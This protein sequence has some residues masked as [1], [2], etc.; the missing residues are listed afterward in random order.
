MAASAKRK[1][2]SEA[3]FA[4][5]IGMSRTG[6]Q[7]AK[8]SGRLVLFPDGSIDMAASAQRMGRGTDPSKQRGTQPTVRVSDND[9]RDDELELP[10][11]ADFLEVK[12]FHERRKVEKLEIEIAKRRGELVERASAEALFFDLARQERDAWLGWPAR[13]AATMAAELGLDAKALE[14]VLDHHLREHL[15]GLA[16]LDL[17]MRADG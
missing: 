14:T 5:E 2:L 7:K 1:G 16:G 3:A 4:A 15:A 17:S 6:V 10:A 12:T 9:E 8:Q 11:S 13:V